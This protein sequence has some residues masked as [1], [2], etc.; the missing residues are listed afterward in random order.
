MVST[1]TK[2]VAPSSKKSLSKEDPRWEAPIRK[3]DWRCLSLFIAITITSLIGCP[4]YIYNQGMPLPVIFLFSFFMI[5]TGLSITAGYH[6]LFS[7]RSYKA[8][9]IVRFFFVVF[10]SAA[11]QESVLAWASQHRE[12]HSFVDTNRDPYS[13]KRGFFYA[14]LGWMIFYKHQLSFDNIT[15]LLKDKILVHQHKYYN[16]WAIATG[17]LLPLALGMLTGYLGGALI[18]SV[19]LRLF[20]VFNSTFFINSICHMFGKCVYDKKASAKDNWAIAFLTYGEGFHNFHHR[21]PRDYRNGIKA[22]HWDPSKWLIYG[23]SKLKLT[24]NLNKVPDKAILKAQK[25]N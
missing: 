7:H 16:L 2:K 11:M 13:I 1:I 5:S 4:L 21:F 3:N 19:A 6:R 17:I 25:S 15:D 9:P 23:L 24:T 22:Y 20:I 18:F 12:H 10:G 8:S 14:H